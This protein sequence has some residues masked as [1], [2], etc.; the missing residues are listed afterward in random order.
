MPDEKNAGII[1][2]IDIARPASRRQFLGT[3]VAAA[4]A[5][6]GAS[7]LLAACGESAT[8]AKP[9]SDGGAA[10]PGQPRL[11]LNG[12]R[13]PGVTLHYQ[14]AATIGSATDVKVPALEKGTTT[15]YIQRVVTDTDRTGTGLATVLKSIYKFSTGTTVQVIVQDSGGKVWPARRVGV[16]SD[17]AYAMKDALATNTLSYGVLKDSLT[18]GNA[19]VHI[20]HS[21][22]IQYYDGVASDYYGNHLDVASRGFCDVFNTTVAGIKLA[23]TTADPSRC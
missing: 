1:P 12:G 4:V 7:A 18:A 15:T 5:A 21:S 6:T 13:D 22:I 23:A 11:S 16:Q 14:M 3:G 2:E 8:A 17:L 9:A 10:A 20:S 19:V